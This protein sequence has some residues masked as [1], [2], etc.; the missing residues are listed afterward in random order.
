MDYVF[1]L[2]EMVLMGQ[3]HTKKANY[4]RVWVLYQLINWLNMWGTQ[5]SGPQNKAIY[6]PQPEPKSPEG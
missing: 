3:I 1:I 4:S 2:T 6:H 5:I